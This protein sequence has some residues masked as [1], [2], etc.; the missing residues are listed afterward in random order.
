MTKSEQFAE[1]LFNSSLDEETKKFIIN[2]LDNF[3]EEEKNDIFEILKNDVKNTENIL[4]LTKIKL[5]TE[6][7]KFDKESKILELEV[8]KAKLENKN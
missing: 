1:L 3:S 6:K 5:Q 2:N 8:L 4:E 7:N